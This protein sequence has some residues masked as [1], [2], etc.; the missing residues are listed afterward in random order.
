MQKKL[1]YSH[2]LD[3]FKSDIK[4][5]WDM[6]KEILNKSR[7]NNFL[8]N[9]FVIN[10]SPITD[11]TTI[12][13]EFNKYFVNIGPNLASNIDSPIDKSFTD[14]LKT[15]NINSFHFK[16]VTENDI[17]DIIKKLK[18]KSS[19]GH[20]KLS[21][22]LLKLIKDDITKPLTCIINQ[23]LKS[24]IFPEKLKFAKVIPIFKKGD[25][26][27]LSNYRPISV[28]PSVSKVF[29]R[30]MHNQLHKY[31][32]EQNLYYNS[33]YGFRTMHS[34]ELATLE[35]IDRVM[36]SMDNNQ[37]PINI[38]LDLSKAF[39]TL[40]HDILL[41]KLQY[42][43]IRNESLQL[44]KSYLSNRYQYTE[45]E[46]ITSES[47]LI[48]TGVPQG[49]ILGPLLFLIYVNDI[50]NA[51]NTFYPI[52]YAD[53][54]TLSATLNTFG[55]N[56]TDIN[57]ELHSIITWLKLNKL[58][59]NIDKTKAMT[60]H[61]FHKTVEQPPIKIGNTT[62]EYVNQFNFLGII[63]D[64]HLT[65]TPHINHIRNKL[66]KVTGVLN[67]LKHMIPKCSLITLYNLL[68][69]P[70]LNYGILLWGAC[71]Q[72]LFKNQKRIIRIIN[73]SRF[74][75]HTEP[76]FKS[77]KLL[78]LNDICTLHELKFCHRLENNIL[79][80]YFCNNI[81]IKNSENHPYLTR[82]LNDYQLPL[83]KHS[84]MKK[85]IRYRIPSAYNNLIISLKA[86]IQTHSF[87]HFSKLIKRHFLE[88]Y[89]ETCTLRDCFV[90]HQR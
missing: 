71:G 74:N 49:S 84:F 22:K 23:T 51:T 9:Y 13:N 64:K 3:K 46:N 43:G 20:D 6:I 14:Y 90:C 8:P 19:S 39:D 60:F 47:S 59:I 79:P 36:T 11:K 81:F 30:V 26:H 37:I 18:D 35:M 24:G 54:T 80:Q 58:S 50:P 48:T 77:L 57:E 2:C 44:F 17:K 10:G 67:K 52:V 87:Q 65:W 63:I 27:S 12:A 73:L 32:N 83:F 21:N 66:S 38:Y 42:Y 28:L 33:Q 61:T 76:I 15:P 62:I 78:K 85:S 82:R 16:L 68:V 88:A 40:D 72:S 69:L 7:T 55:N 53:D 86:K 34:T 75:A 25:K 89:G 1:Y 70:H 41:C 5:T 4:K 31:F 29:E 56:N 45:I